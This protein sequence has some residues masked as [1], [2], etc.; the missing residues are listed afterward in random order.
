ME[1]FAA[2]VGLTDIDGCSIIFMDPGE[3]RVWTSVM[4]QLGCV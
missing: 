1:Q 2:V 3:Q 4:Q